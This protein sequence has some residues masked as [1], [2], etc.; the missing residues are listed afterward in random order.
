MFGGGKHQRLARILA[1][2]GMAG[3]GASSSEASLPQQNPGRGPLDGDDEVDAL[4]ELWAL[5][6]ISATVLQM[7]VAAACNVAP[8][9]QMQVLKALGTSGI[10]ANNAHRDLER[11]LNLGRLDLRWRLH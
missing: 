10:H 9:P 2:G 1:I 11:K 8:R 6:L 5:G 4:I 7:I 3:Q